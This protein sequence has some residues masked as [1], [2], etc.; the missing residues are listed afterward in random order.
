MSGIRIDYV[1]GD[2]WEGVYVDG[3]LFDEGQS[4]RPEDWIRLIRTHFHEDL[5]SEHREAEIDGHLPERL[6]EVKFV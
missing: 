1:V 5:Q 3:R 4:L 6:S 2:D